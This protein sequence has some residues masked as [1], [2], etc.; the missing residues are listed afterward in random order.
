MK[1]WQS[2]SISD[3][4]NDEASLGSPIQHSASFS[5]A[6]TVPCREEI[7]SSNSASPSEITATKLNGTFHTEDAKTDEAEQDAEKYWIEKDM[8]RLEIIANTEK[9][10]AEMKGELANSLTAFQMASGANL[11]LQSELEK[12][13]TNIT[14]MEE[15]TARLAH[16]LDAAEMANDIIEKDLAYSRRDRKRQ[17]GRAEEALTLLEADPNKKT[18]ANLLQVKAEAESHHVLTQEK[19]E[20]KIDSLESQLKERCDS[21]AS[22]TMSLSRVADSDRWQE[23]KKEMEEWKIQANN[24]PNDL[25]TAWLACEEWKGKYENLMLEHASLKKDFQHVEEMNK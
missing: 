13:T 7:P 18:I 17:F 2:R 19:M 4:S 12:K 16:D 3:S 24:L 9:T 21:I 6:L 14:E 23:I 10:M 20:S 8:E 22:L 15:D 1:V 11:K 25:Q 5:T